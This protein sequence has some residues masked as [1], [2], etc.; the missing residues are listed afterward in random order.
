MKRCTPS[1]L[2][3]VLASSACSNSGGDED[4]KKDPPIGADDDSKVGS[5]DAGGN[6]DPA[7]PSG[8]TDTA[9]GDAAAGDAGGELRPCPPKCGPPSSVFLDNERLAEVRITFD[10]ETTSSAGYFPDEWLD[11]LWERWQHCGPYDNYV[12]VT[13]QYISPDGV[14]DVTLED[15]GMRLRGSK[16]RGTNELQGFKLS[17]DDRLEEDQV[18]DDTE[19]T[20]RRRFAGL[21]R[22]NTLSVEDDPS[23]MIQCLAYKYARNFGVPAPR[24][25]HLL[26]YVN[27]E[28]YG[29]M[30][31]VEEVDD[32]RW[33]DHYFGTTR[34]ALY[35]NSGGCDRILPNGDVVTFSDSLADLRYYG[36]E[37]AGPYLSAYNPQR[38]QE[39]PEEELIPMLKC[40]DDD[41]TPDDDDFKACISDWIDV[42]EWLDLI[43]VESVMPTLESFMVARN[44]YL[45]YHPDLEAPKGARFLLY[46][47]DYDTAFHKQ[48][49]TPSDCDLFT[50]VTGWYTGNERPRLAQRLVRVFKDEYCDSLRRFIDDAFSPEVVD[51]MAAGIERGV[52]VML[53]QDEPLYS[54]EQWQSEI[55]A[56]RDFVSERR[57]A[58]RQQ[59]DEHCGE[60]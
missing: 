37:F 51:D 11:L 34:G 59:V 46:S 44:F 8:K 32:G 53:E 41:A 36:D 25:N 55:S 12:P 24:C 27:D 60:P 54:S 28:F 16:S 50:A 31:N 21:N 19:T 13:M 35:E 15:V 18:D 22:L 47:W 33:L 40:G 14:G 6:S 29:L 7:T 4:G 1:L 10:E 26:V 58:A 2:C 9:N 30:Q 39:N 43:A 42:G 38:E 56:I 20:K 48:S 52:D 57:E 45:Y 3:F 23:L 17:F 5:K 49:C